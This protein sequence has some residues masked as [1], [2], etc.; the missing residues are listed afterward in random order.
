MPRWQRW[1][2]PLAVKNRFYFLCFVQN[3]IMYENVHIQ[4]LWNQFYMLKKKIQCFKWILLTCGD[5][6]I[7]L[8]PKWFHY[9]G[10]E[11][12]CCWEEILQVTFK[13]RIKSDKRI[14]PTG[15][16]VTDVGFRF[17]IEIKFYTHTPEGH[18]PWENSPVPVWL[19]QACD[20]CTALFSGV[21]RENFAMVCVWDHTIIE[22]T[23]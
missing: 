12:D 6:N 23:Q 15:I 2:D 7:E 5:V 17:Q 14:F 22:T 21:Y 19:K 20:F 18:N 8:S 11:A 4:H 16:S 1:P 9:L 3:T 13:L 10:Q